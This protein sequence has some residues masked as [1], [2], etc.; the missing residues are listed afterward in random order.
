MIHSD[1]DRPKVLM[2]GTFGLRPKATLRSR[3]L[4]IAQALSNRW[5]FNLMTT[6]WD[7]PSDA[8][9]RW[10]EHDVP[11]GNTRTVR[12]ALFPFAIREMTAE[13][14]RI[15]PALVHLFKPKGFGDLAARRLRRRLPV[16]VDMDDWEGDGGWN[17][18]GG[19][20]FVQRRLFDWQERTWPRLASAV[21]VASRELERRAIDLGADPNRIFYVPNGLSRVHFDT[22]ARARAD[23][24]NDA[25]LSISTSR[26]MIGL[27][28]RFVEFDVSSVARVMKLV[29][30]RFPTARLLIVGASASGE[31]ERLLLDTAHQMGIVEVFDIRGWTEPDAI[32]ALIS[33]CDVAIHPFDDNTVN[34]AK[35]SVKLLE[36]MASGTPVVTNSVGENASMIQNGESG[37]LVAPGDI[38]ALADGVIGLLEDAPRARLMGESARR[39]V[40]QHYLWDHLATR[41]AVAYSCGLQVHQ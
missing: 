5:S 39:R 24:A 36:L 38:R 25:K 26:P 7:N 12:P 23:T 9:A 15:H 20:G 21:T 41:V 28:T 31:A 14:D 6:P 10:F 33:S 2:L 34:R 29:V 19:Y 40:A 22:I 27:Y 1:H 30:E 3:A 17:E 16:V 13:A 8:G 4:A 18:I 35:C 11:V 37:L 32:P